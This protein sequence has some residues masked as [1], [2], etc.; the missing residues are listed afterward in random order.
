MGMDAKLI[1]YSKPDDLPERGKVHVKL[2]KGELSDS[3]VQV[4]RAGGEN[5][6]HSHHHREGFWFVLSGR[7][8][9]YTTDDE[10]IGEFG[11]HEGVLI[12]RDY[13]YWFES[14]SGEDLELLQVESMDEVNFDR[15]D[16]IWADPAMNT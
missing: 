5:K 10:I 8:R 9:F 7:A 4:V 1:K 14:C 16:L 3:M 6:L 15:T 11:K 13:Q 12:P 2:V